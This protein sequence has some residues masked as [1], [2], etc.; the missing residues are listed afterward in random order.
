VVAKLRDYAEEL[1]LQYQIVECDGCSSD[2]VLPSHSASTILIP[3]LCPACALTRESRIAEL[4]QQLT[5][6]IALAGERWG[7]LQTALFERDEARRMYCSL[8][9]ATASEAG[10]PYGTHLEECRAE[11]ER[12]W[13]GSGEELFPL[14]QPSR[15]R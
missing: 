9:A 3:I 10:W 4:E 8:L 15:A 5:H 2:V 7:A 12:R 13:P 6:M 11:A 1:E 14:P